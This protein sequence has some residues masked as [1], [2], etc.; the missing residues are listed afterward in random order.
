MD[1]L[2][3]LPNEILFQILHPL[4]LEVLLCIR[5]TCRFFW[6]FL[7]SPWFWSMKAQQEFSLSSAVGPSSSPIGW[8]RRL[9]KIFSSEFPASEACRLGEMTI[10]PHLIS[11]VPV[12]AKLSSF[13]AAAGGGQLPVIE[14]LLKAERLLWP[15]KDAIPV[16]AENGHTEV[17][18]HLSQYLTE[19]DYT[20]SYFRAYRR[21]H[22]GVMRFFLSQA[23]RFQLDLEELL[24][25]AVRGD[26][27]DLI[28]IILEYT[29]SE[30]DLYNVLETAVYNNSVQVVPNLL[31][32]Y[33][34]QGR[35]ILRMN[36]ILEL[37][38]GL[39]R[40]LMIK[41]LVDY[42][43]PASLISANLDL[44]NYYVAKYLLRY[45]NIRE[46]LQ[47]SIEEEEIKMMKF[48]CEEGCPSASLLSEIYR[49]CKGKGYHLATQYLK[50]QL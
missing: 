30:I 38:I 49:W 35:R 26:N 37:A 31:E 8:Y 36:E 1:S 46:L 32:R 23:G 39:D 14:Y 21:G 15:I 12:E 11:T 9:T 43:D 4:S 40:R 20:R 44:E 7:D 13:I 22:E 50:T 41:E 10:I 48:I 2:I 34:S 25:E 42:A 33:P 19:F 47:Y 27:V 6:N 16:A 17:I 28:E 18:E 24:L 3:D 5:T 29:T 45:S